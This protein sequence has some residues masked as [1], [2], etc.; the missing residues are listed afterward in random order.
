MSDIFKDWSFGGQLRAKRNQQAFTLRAY[1]D[2]I[3]SD[4]GNL[5]KLERS[6][7]DPPTSRENF[8]A[9]VK[10]LDLDFSEAAFMMSA[11]FNFHL[12][13]LRARFD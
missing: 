8:E 9:V 6:E 7:L 5:S 13:K 3:G 1:A 4:P 10:P 11:C 12:A 2:L